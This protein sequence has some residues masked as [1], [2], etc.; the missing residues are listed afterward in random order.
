MW[1]KGAGGGGWWLLSRWRCCCALAGWER[2]QSFFLSAKHKAERPEQADECRSDSAVAARARDALTTASLSICLCSFQPSGGTFSIIVWIW[3]S[4]V[5]ARSF[6]LNP[7]CRRT[8]GSR[9]ATPAACQ[10]RITLGHREEPW[11]ILSRPVTWEASMWGC[12][13][14][15]EQPTGGLNANNKEEKKK[16]E[17]AFVHDLP[18]FQVIRELCPGLSGFF[19]FIYLRYRAW[20]S[21]K[22]NWQIEKTVPRRLIR[23][24]CTHASSTQTAPWLV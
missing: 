20:C 4:T 5:S 21:V 16:C 1:I 6:S 13:G 9:C 14:G 15:G 3:F 19:K 12:V 24:E 22:R 23:H 18:S 10:V 11:E 8:F 2:S 7:N 17:R